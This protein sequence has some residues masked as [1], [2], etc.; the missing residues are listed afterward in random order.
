M[1]ASTKSRPRS[2]SCGQ[3]DLLNA[4]GERSASQRIVAAVE[5]VLTEGR[6]RPA[7]LG[8]SATTPQMADAIIRALR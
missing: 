2:A 3:G 1:P 5:V 4:A 6:V 7:D 8:G